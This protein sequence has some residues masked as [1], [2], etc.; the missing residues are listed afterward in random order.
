MGGVFS[1]MSG[2]VSV[3]ERE[4]WSVSGDD[5]RARCL[6]YFRR[7]FSSPRTSQ[8]SLN[9]YCVNTSQ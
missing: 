7:S 1:L 3:N 9:Y 5:R 8:A 4:T 2:L 6:S